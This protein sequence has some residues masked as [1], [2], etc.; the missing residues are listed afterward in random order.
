MAEQVVQQCCSSVGIG[1]FPRTFGRLLPQ[2]RVE[3]HRLD[4]RRRQPLPA[5][6]LSEQVPIRWLIGPGLGLIG[7]NLLLMRDLHADTGWGG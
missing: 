3:P 4:A 1:K 6:R 7:L 5:G 2:L